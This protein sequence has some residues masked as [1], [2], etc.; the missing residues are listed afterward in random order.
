MG[1]H[2]SVL[3][4]VVSMEYFLMCEPALLS[5]ARPLPAPPQTVPWPLVWS[6]WTTFCLSTWPWKLTHLCNAKTECSR[7]FQVSPCCQLPPVLFLPAQRGEED[8]SKSMSKTFLASCHFLQVPLPIFT[9]GSL[10]VASPPQ[11]REKIQNILNDWIAYDFA[12]LIDDL[13]VRAGMRGETSAVVS[14]WDSS[15]IRS[16]LHKSQEQGLTQIEGGFLKAFPLEYAN[17][18]L[19]LQISDNTTNS[20]QQKKYSSKSCY[21]YLKKYPI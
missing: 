10:R 5:Q 7:P 2:Q 12:P 6:S 14:I 17:S 1:A 21:T 13:G 4:K 20:D 11:N 15:W 16:S 9:R 19:F 3:S 8:S 18:E